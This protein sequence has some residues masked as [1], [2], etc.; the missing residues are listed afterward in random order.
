M[1]F[2]WLDNKPD[3]GRPRWGVWIALCVA[4]LAWWGLVELVRWLLG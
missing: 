3:W 1:G 2:L 4:G